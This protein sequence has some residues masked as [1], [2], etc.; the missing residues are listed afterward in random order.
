ALSGQSTNRSVRAKGEAD[1]PIKPSDDSLT[2]DQATQPAGQAQTPLDAALTKLDSQQPHRVARLTNIRHW[3]TPD[4][5][6][7]AIDLDHEV[8]F[9]VGRV[10]FPDRIFFD[11]YGTRL[12]SDLVGKS[13]EVE[14]GFLHR[15]RVA[16]F[17][18][19]MARVV[20]DVDDV[21]EYSAFLLPN[22]YRLIIDI[23]GKLP[24]QQTAAAKPQIKPTPPKS[25]S[26]DKDIPSA[27]DVTVTQIK[28]AATSTKASGNATA[29]LDQAEK[30]KPGPIR[31]AA[32]KESKPADSAATTTKTKPAAEKTVEVAKVEPVKVANDD[33]TLK[34]G[35]SA[36]AG[37]PTTAPP[38]QATAPQESS[39][40]KRKPAETAAAKPSASTH[41]AAPT[42][43]GDRSLIRALGLK[44]GKIVV[45]A[46]H[47]GHD[48]RALRPKCL[49][50][51]NLV[52][53]VS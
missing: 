46:G 52:L 16:Q 12:A 19:N 2:T 39:R 40:N 17:K 24:V 51:K 38:F 22:P 48:T 3:S 11:L 34:E 23:H 50:G 47:G 21:A 45:D 4:Y 41:T 36:N 8:P 42:A 49:M 43:S 28:P 7:V 35:E 53:G 1:Q 5:T 18:A 30:S 13:F 32:D 20:L 15:I 26:V 29:A 27:S 37:K 14:A 31:V 9:Q 25:T 6:R 44:I 33:R 10:P